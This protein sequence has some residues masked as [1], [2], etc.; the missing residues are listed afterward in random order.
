MRARGHGAHVIVTEVSPVRAIEAVMDGFPVLPMPKAAPLGDLF[1]TLTGNINVID[2]DDFLRMKDGAVVCNSGHFDVEINLTALREVAG[3][4]RRTRQNVQEYTL[5][6]GKRIRVLA[7]GRLVNLSAAEGH[8]AAVMDM[9]F[10]NQALA[11][12]YLAQRHGQLRP[13]VHIVPPELD[14]EVAQLKLRSLG[15]SIDKLTRE[16]RAYL[17]AFEHGT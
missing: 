6:G 5:P 9:S 8:P 12:Q 4:P 14:G 15:F 2:Q 1:V 10:A 17:A 11:C 16:Q 13:G 3:K 7:E